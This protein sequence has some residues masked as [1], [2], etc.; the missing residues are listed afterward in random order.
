MKLK[1]LLLGSA[2]ALITVPAVH[3]ADAVIA[4]PEPNDHVQ[5]CDMYGAGFFYIPGTETCLKISGELRVQYNYRQVDVG[6]NVPSAVLPDYEEEYGDGTWYAR[7]NFDAREETDYGTLRSYIRTESK[8]G[9]NAG[10]ESDLFVRDAYIELGGLSVGYRTSRVEL[11]GLPGQ[12]FDGVYY[13]G[14]RVMYADY[15]FAAN[16]FSVIAGIQLDN[17]DDGESI[18]LYIRPEYS[19]DMFTI[20][21]VYGQDASEDNGAFGIYATFTPMEGLT[22]QGYYNHQTGETQFGS[23]VI[24]DYDADDYDTWGI[25]A[26]YDVTD[27][28][29]V[30]LGYYA[31]ENHKITS[32]I[33]GSVI[34]LSDF[35]GYSFNL[36]W[37]VVPNLVMQ[38]GYNHEE[39]DDH[40]MEEDNFRVR[41]QRN[42]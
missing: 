24:A 28:V 20:G 37:T 16:G 36:A 30:A 38:L 33:D 34:G 1:S 35:Q 5:V 12:M 42:F 17:D 9:T 32:I 6:G 8:N 25:G 22:V 3:A 39:S 4:E 15:T 26:S 27:D 7:V 29:N 10:D 31:S 18:D 2:A 41:I 19:S 21:A 14:G 23:G 13:G 40:D 11:T